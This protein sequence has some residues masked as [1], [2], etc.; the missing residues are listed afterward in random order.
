ME[1]RIDGRR[2]RRAGRVPLACALVAAAVALSAGCGS[3]DETSAEQP[4]RRVVQVESV[5]R[6]R[7]TYARARFN[8]MCAGCHSLQDA[9]ARGPRFD[10]DRIGGITEQR[11]RFVIAFG[12]PGMP[13]W[14][15]V[16]SGREY[17]ELVAYVSSV[18]RDDLEGED[19]WHW[20]IR[21]RMEGGVLRPGM[22]G[23]TPEERRRLAAL[24]A[25]RRR[26]AEADAE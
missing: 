5:A 20:Q 15:H 6:D 18:A 24:E 8:E 14:Q 2:L 1:T 25:L 13:E 22:L 10:L 9:G 23:V 12:E 17:E 11:A 3:G 19:D 26:N 4:A 7:W 16:L 21:L